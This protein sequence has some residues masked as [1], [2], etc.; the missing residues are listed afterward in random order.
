MSAIVAAVGKELSPVTK[1]WVSLAM[2]RAGVA[3]RDGSGVVFDGRCGLGQA[4]LR[5]SPNQ[6]ADPAT[7]GEGTWLAA[8]VRLDGRDNVRRELLSRGRR[9]SPNEPDPKLVLHAYAVWGEA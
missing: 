4:L 7:L 8:D 1:A 6:E 5:T 2:A 9:L 3:S